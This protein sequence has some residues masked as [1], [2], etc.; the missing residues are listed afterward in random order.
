[1]P[2]SRLVSEWGCGSQP[3]RY[4]NECHWEPDGILQP[5]DMTAG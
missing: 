2:A 4:L 3:L 1:V 5:S